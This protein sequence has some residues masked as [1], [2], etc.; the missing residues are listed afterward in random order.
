MQDDAEELAAVLETTESVD[1][2]ST[3]T[4][5]STGGVD[6]AKVT[7]VPVTERLGFFPSETKMKD[8]NDGFKI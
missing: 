4:G 3:D 8:H 5:D 1:V 7:E 6:S 2:D